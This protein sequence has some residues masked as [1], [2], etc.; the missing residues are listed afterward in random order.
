MKARRSWSA[1]RLCGETVCYR[2]VV[3]F[4]PIR[5][6]EFEEECESATAIVVLTR[7]RRVAVSPWVRAGVHFIFHFLGFEFDLYYVCLQQQ[8]FRDGEGGPPAPRA[9]HAGLPRGYCGERD[10]A[11]AA[12]Q[13]GSR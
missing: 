12:R 6:R 5:M 2:V 7:W 1:W 13:R 10:G 4:N 9:G 11:G 3:C 8:R